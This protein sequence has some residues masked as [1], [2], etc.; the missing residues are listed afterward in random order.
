[1]Y[2]CYEDSYKT[3]VFYSFYIILIKQTNINFA[4]CDN[5]IVLTLFFLPPVKPI[6]ILYVMRMCILKRICV[7]L[8]FFNLQFSVLSK[9]N[10]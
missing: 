5:K 2:F 3:I 9:Q 8:F 7:L 6:L 10:H 4:N 1:M